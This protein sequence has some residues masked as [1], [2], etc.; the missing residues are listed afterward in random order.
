MTINGA[1]VSML[2]DTGSERSIVTERTAERLRLPPDTARGSVLRGVGGTTQ[3]SDAVVRSVRL[4]NVELIRP[5][6]SIGVLSKSGVSSKLVDGVL[7]SD[8]L[9]A[10]DLELDLDAGR[11]ALYDV[12]GCAGSFVTW[13]PA[14][15]R[16]GLAMAYGSLPFFPVYV[17][18]RALTALLDTGADRSLISARGAARLGISPEMLAADPAGFGSGV[19]RERVGIRLHRFD[20]VQVGAEVAH[21]RSMVVADLPPLPLDVLIGVDFVRVHRVWLSYATS[22]LFLAPLPLL[23]LTSVP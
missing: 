4:A 6:F 8:L 13:G 5:P 10:Y 2:L 17:N 22:Q 23:R 19:G 15:Q 21:G 12:R 9:R 18:G 11:M 7:G 14:S 1:P 3:H 20:S 16:V